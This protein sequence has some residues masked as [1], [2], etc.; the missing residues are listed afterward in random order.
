[1]LLFV[2]AIRGFMVHGCLLLVPL[3]LAY[4]RQRTRGH[5]DEFRCAPSAREA[6][7]NFVGDNGVTDRRC[8]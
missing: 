2:V 6:F 4:L 5:A 8:Y 1:M 7:R 3:R